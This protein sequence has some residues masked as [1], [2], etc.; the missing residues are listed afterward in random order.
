VVF[1]R[2]HTVLAQLFFAD[3]LARLK[4]SRPGSTRAT[5]TQPASWWW[6]GAGRGGFYFGWSFG[7]DELRVELAIDSGVRETNK[8]FFD[9]LQDQRAIIEAEI[10]S[11]LK[12]EHLERRKYAN[13]F[14][15]R[16]AKITDPIEELERTKHWA[17]ETMLKFIDVF[18]ERIKQLP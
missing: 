13:I 8:K 12:W 7:R 18:Q 1:Y 15:A 3:L 6:F 17:L 14:L 5:K 16:P 2:T 10:G 4:E 9:L 11:P